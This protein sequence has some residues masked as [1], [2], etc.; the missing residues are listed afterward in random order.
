[1]ATI[2]ANIE[3]KVGIVGFAMLVCE[4]P[5]VE[6]LSHPDDGIAVRQGS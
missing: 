5:E 4:P 1:M 2:I 6:V 3:R